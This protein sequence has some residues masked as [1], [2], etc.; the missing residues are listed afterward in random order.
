LDALIEDM[1]TSDIK[2][3]KKEAYLRDGGY[4][5]LNYFE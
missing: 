3:M 2:T 5:I 1:M 4:R